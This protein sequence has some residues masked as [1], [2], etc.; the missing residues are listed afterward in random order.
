LGRGRFPSK[1][2]VA[3]IAFTTAELNVFL[4]LFSGFNTPC[5]TRTFHIVKETTLQNVQI[6]IFIK[7]NQ[8]FRR[9][10]LKINHQIS[11]K[12]YLKYIYT[13]T[14]RN[15]KKNGIGTKLK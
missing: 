11:L 2:F 15:R 3:E 6:Y 14:N 5:M 8:I 4:G 9:N 13:Q 1:F 12:S 10:K 7:V